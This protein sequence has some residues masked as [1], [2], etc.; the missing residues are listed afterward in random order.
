MNRLLEY[1][2]NH[3][4]LV[5]A[6]AILFILTLIIELR[7]RARGSSLVGVN[8][9]SDSRTKA[10]RFWISDR[11]PITRQDTSSMPGTSPLPNSPRARN[12]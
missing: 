1:T 9:P 11:P 5:A 12:R 7:Q 8:V 10:P 4:F 3:P 6:A 2:A